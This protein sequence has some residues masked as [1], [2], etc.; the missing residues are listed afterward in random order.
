M[1]ACIVIWKFS[2]EGLQ[3]DRSGILS[4]LDS[5]FKIFMKVKYT[6]WK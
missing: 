5:S 1:L 2:K 6:T 4:L 3:L